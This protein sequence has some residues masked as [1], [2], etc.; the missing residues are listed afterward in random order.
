MWRRYCCKKGEGMIPSLESIAPRPSGPTS[1]LP[2]HHLQ[3]N[4][5]VEPV[6]EQIKE[7]HIYD[8]CDLKLD[9]S[10]AVSGVSDGKENNGELLHEEDTHCE[11]ISRFLSYT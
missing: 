2:L 8:K 5:S 4:G 6:Y 9:N 1:S 7:C 3:M 11:E 10:S